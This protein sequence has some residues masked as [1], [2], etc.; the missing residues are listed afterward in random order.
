MVRKPQKTRRT[1]R[2]RLRYQRG[3]CGVGGKL[4]G[5]QLAKIVE[6]PT[7]HEFEK[8]DF[9]WDS[10]KWLLAVPP[11]PW[12]E[13]KDDYEQIFL[14]L[15]EPEPWRACQHLGI[16]VNLVKHSSRYTCPYTGY[17]H[18]G[19]VPCAVVTKEP[20]QYR[21]HVVH[22]CGEDPLV[23]DFDF[24]RQMKKDY[25]SIGVTDIH[26]SLLGPGYTSGTLKMD[27]V[28]KVDSGVICL[29]N[30]DYLRV[31]IRLWFNK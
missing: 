15:I 17:E 13:C 19:V 28:S 29:S 2:S 10:K 5:K 31:A 3:G 6:P 23:L 4:V 7:A 12:S 21:D 9:L 16:N 25:W 14:Y 20:E 27:G 22:V 11:Y 1:A 8:G 26:R 18:Y 24:V 30:G